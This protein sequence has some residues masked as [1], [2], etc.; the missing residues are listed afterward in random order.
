VKSFDDQNG[1]LVG[2]Y[3]GRTEAT[4]VVGEIA[5]KPEPRWR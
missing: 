4:R 3:A 1:E 2:R 5:Y